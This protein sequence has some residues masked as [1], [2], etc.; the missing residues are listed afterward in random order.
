[1]RTDLE[2]LDVQVIQA[3]TEHVA[4]QESRQLWIM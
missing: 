3:H 1:M 4:S 2:T